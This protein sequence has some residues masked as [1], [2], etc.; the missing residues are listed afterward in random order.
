MFDIVVPVYNS[1]QHVR[2]C[3]TAVFSHSTLPFHLYVVNDASD[4][5]TTRALR[6]LLAEYDER[7][8]TLIE[9]EENLGYLASINRG[10]EAG[11]NPGVLCLN[12]DTFVTPG[13]LEKLR[14][15]FSADPK[16]GVV[17]PVSNWANWTRICW[18]IPQGYNVLDFA[19][20]V[21]EVSEKTLP[22]IHNASGFYFAVRRQTFDELGLFDEVYGFGY[23]EEADFCMRALDAGYRVVVDDSLFIFHDGWGSF[24]EESRNENMARNK[25]IFMERWGA[26]Y[27]KISEEWKKKNPIQYVPKNLFDKS[28][29]EPE[30][31]RKT[32]AASQTDSDARLCPIAPEEARKRLDW[33]TSLDT[34][35][36][37]LIASIPDDAPMRDGSRNKIIYILPAVGL[38]GGIIS[39]LQVVNE[40]I[41]QG[42][43]A[44]IVTYGKVDEEVYRLFPTYFR[45]HS[46]PDMQSMVAEFPDC[47]LVVAT[48]WDSVYPTVLLK[49]LRPQ[50]RLAYFVQDYEPDFYIPEHPDLAKKAERTYYL[51]KDQIGKTRWLQRM[52]APY[53][54]RFH[55]IPLGLNLD[56]Y[57]D[58]GEERPPQVISLARP[59]S[60]RRNFPMVKEVFA[61]IH[62]RRPDITF[63]LYGHGYDDKDLDFPCNSYGALNDMKD[64]AGALNE[65]TVL[66]D[67]STFQGFGRPGLEAMACGT[68]AVLTREGGITQYAKHEHNCLLIDPCDRDDIV[69]KILELMDDESKRKRLIENGDKTAE[70]Y[71]LVNEGK[72]T[73]ALFRKILAGEELEAY[74]PEPFAIAEN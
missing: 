22:D 4:A 3:L 48:S 21:D 35:L 50:L 37:E 28:I 32:S 31:L 53:D 10:I 36:D 67:C 69:G 25:A 65:S 19:E 2:A 30:A 59:S 47:D 70:E 46:F 63:A 66:V 7:L 9:N 29:N 51:I 52:V 20:K 73:A 64:V 43:D 62:R 6:A 1:M 60:I 42:F 33:M 17:N 16:I 14:A 57:H 49:S 74:E 15:A 26:Q 11:G 68:A 8:C 23:W 34:P 61:E 55:R 56:F 38:Y 71:S 39:V 54:G 40:L 58:R 45:A 13:H 12:S 27:D 41:L 5:Y 44:N 24:Q 72:R 18:S